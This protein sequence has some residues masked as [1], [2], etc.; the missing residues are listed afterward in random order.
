MKNI[1]LFFLL[2]SM[3]SV[4]KANIKLPA[5]VG[6]NMVLQRDHNINIWGWADPE[7][8]LSVEFQG[9][10]FVA[11]ADKDGK[12]KLTLPA[13][14]AG[15]PFTMRLKGKDTIELTNILIGD[16]WLASGQSN[17]EWALENIKNAKEEIQNANFPQ[18]RL[19]T[20]AKEYDFK[21][22][23]DVKSKG[24][25]ACS[26]EKV[27]KFSAI[28]FLFG[29][30]IHQEINVP[31]GLIFSAWGGTTAEAW[32]SPDGLKEVPSFK[33]KLNALSNAGADKY[34]AFKAKKEAWL[35]ENDKIDR[36]R[37]SNATP[38]SAIDL[39]TAD[40]S[41]MNQPA[42]WA[43]NKDL[44]G[45][46]GTV[47]FRKEIEVSAQDMGKPLELSF[48][49]IL[50]TDSVF[51]NG[52]FVGTTT[53]FSQKR[54]YKVPAD[55]VKQGKNL[56]VVRIKG[57]QTF[58]GMADSPTEMYAQIGE[59]K[60]SLEDKWLYKTA[61][62]ISDFPYDINFSEF[63]PMM[64]TVP[65]VLHNA[66][67][68]PVVQYPIKGVIWYQG[69]SNADD[70]DEAL[71]YYSL[72]P[73][74]IKDWRREWGYD[75]PFLFVQLAGYQPDKPEP[76]DYAWAH[77]RE[78]QF[79]TLSLP[80]T[81][82]ATA[83]DIGEVGDIHPKNKQDVANRLVLAAKKVAYQ[84]DVVYSGPV[85]KSMTIEGNKLR[86]RF[87]NVGS[88]FLIKDKYAYPKGF[89]IAGT[90][91]NFVWAKAIVE[92]ND[93]VVYADNVQQPMA[94]R[95]NWGNS[96]DGNIYNKENLPAVPFRTDNW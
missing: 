78:A 57:V 64:P 58:G 40:W 12:W 75:F 55:L 20:V 16:V 21:P 43:T 77:L 54:K 65:L 60:I 26:S 8:N 32:M 1:L 42:Q 84:K 11:S 34:N 36:G 62:D 52:Q 48:G 81:C 89:A 69:E 45:Y 46:C 10:Q 51:V 50:M 91:K 18:I 7:E 86:L 90:D 22:R 19:F 17:M 87:E 95:Y 4:L 24:W 28:A 27:P 9:K 56:I 96:P 2:F 76:A 67:I 83:I 39:N 80:N 38:W 82:M 59:T 23:E 49:V 72:F 94:V 93:I 47:W 25:E 14:P 31:V 85:L 37:M 41:A 29:R 70:M 79:K 73:A 13:Y 53:G 33:E 92:G 44:K 3:S 66:M 30:K 15:G 74:L 6:N 5:L 71:N 63:T 68:A 35:K 61:P 88:G